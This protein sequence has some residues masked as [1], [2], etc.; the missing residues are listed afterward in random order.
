MNSEIADIL[1][2]DPGS[3]RSILG[4]F[5]TAAYGRVMSAIIKGGSFLLSWVMVAV[6]VFKLVY[7]LSETVYHL[8]KPRPPSIALL[9]EATVSPS[10]HGSLGP[11]PQ[12]S[13]DSGAGRGTVLQA[14][15]TA[16]RGGIRAG[17]KTLLPSKCWHSWCYYSLHQGW[18]HCARWSC[19][20]CMALAGLHVA[21]CAQQARPGSGCPTAVPVLS[22]EN[23]P[24]HSNHSASRAASQIQR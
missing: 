11:L 4:T 17:H 7:H 14:C 3:W 2:S 10:P 21:A 22:G 1:D 15:S 9:A 16:R 24:R 12:S 20:L 18:P 6:L 5:R 19:A 23:R 13:A 8:F